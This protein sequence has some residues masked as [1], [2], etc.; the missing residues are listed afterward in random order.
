MAF[1][2]L[3][4][5]AAPPVVV[6]N[7]TNKCN[8]K[9]RH[10]YQEAGERL[11]ESEGMNKLLKLVVSLGVI[12]VIAWGV[13]YFSK[14]LLILMRGIVGLVAVVLIAAIV[15]SLIERVQRSGEIKK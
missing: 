11:T 6:W 13:V 10:C 1:C 8:L 2:I 3:K 7:F 15:V 14:D 5:F 12:I 4:F 9:W